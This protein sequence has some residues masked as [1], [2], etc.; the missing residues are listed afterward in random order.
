MITLHYNDTNGNEVTVDIHE[1]DTSYRYRA[2][3]EKPQLVLKFSLPEYTEFP[4]GTWCFFQNEKFTLWQPQ[5]IKK[6]GTRDI[7]YTITFGTDEELMGLCKMR[8]TVDHRLKWSMCAKPHEFIEEIVKNLNA[9]EGAENWTVGE[10]LESTEKTVEF[11]HTYIDDALQSVA[12]EFETE[13]E[14]VDKCISLHK[15]EYFKSNPLALSYGRGNGFIPNVGRTTQSDAQPIKRLYVQ[16]GEDNIDR[17]TYG[18]NELLL[19]K[20]QSL[21][22]EGRTY[23]TD[24][25]GLYIERT[26]KVSDAVKEDSLDCSEIYPSRVGTVSSAEEINADKNWWDFIDNSIPSELNF[27]DYV[28]EGETATIRFQTGML[29]GDKEFEFKYKHAER[30][31]QLVPQEIDGVT[32]PNATFKPEIGDTYAVFGI[33]LPDAYICN[34]EDQTGASWDMFREAAK[35]MYENE[36][37]KFTFTGTLQALWTKRNWLRV[38]CR[39]KVG[40][41]ILFTDEQFAKDGQSIRITG[42]K[43]YLYA[44][45]APTIELASSVSGS[46]VTSQLKQI[47][48]TEVVINDT[49]N[50]ILQFAKRRFRDAK[51]T[52]SALQDSLLSFSEGITP[53]TVQTMAMLVGDESLQFRFVDAKE[54]LNVVEFEITYGATTKQLHCPHGFLQHMTLGITTLSSAHTASEYKCWEI[55]EYL[56]PVLTDTAQVYY[57]YAVVDRN[58]TDAKGEFTIAAKAVDM[59]AVDGKYYLLVGILN[60][61]NEETRSYVNLYGYTE[62]LPSRITTEKIVSAD[63]N[64]YLDLRTGNMKLGDKLTYIDGVLTIDFVMADGASIGDW[65]IKDGKIVST[66]ESGN[67][68]TL[69]AKNGTISLETDNNEGSNNLLEGVG[70][71]IKLDLQSGIVQVRAKKSPSYSTGTSYMSPSGIFSNLAGT[72][73]VSV[74]TGMT[75]RGAIVGLGFANVDKSDWA[76]NAEQTMVSGVY[77]RASNNGTAPAFGGLFFGLKAL[78]FVK[79]ITYIDD[80]ASADT[81]QLSAY[82]TTI[83]G[84]A[85]KGVTKTIYLPADAQEGQEIEVIQMGAGVIRIDTSDGSHIYDD[86]SENEYYDVGTGQT[87]VARRV[88]YAINSTG[89]DIWTVRRY[90]F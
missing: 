53:I 8:N 3:M 81:C 47:E 14:I 5:N 34:N 58:D 17:S 84:L 18:S 89:Y 78:G 72:E 59:D 29:A 6:N 19:P 1:D 71:V 50:D 46:S 23:T 30:R 33:M 22:Y 80:D 7:A 39:M 69:D 32:M 76:M 38:G 67:I 20:S 31:F 35:Y 83:I 2:L 15:V 79:R 40:S 86:T 74:T 64:S 75:H 25:D 11:N 13:W 57:L 87:L 65:Y 26:D 51:G 62:I 70:S 12:D 28:I 73:G 45:Y 90:S 42:I 56:S 37:Q 27:N 88:R 44:P 41:Y 9:K 49:K 61:E 66:L 48:Q 68:I 63:G 85:N 55:A 21:E 77:G 4:V 24:A 16:G 60:S 52:L 36:D 10:C 54:T 82:S 43:D